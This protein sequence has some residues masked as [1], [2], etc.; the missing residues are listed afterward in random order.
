MVQRPEGLRVYP[1]DQWRPRRFRSHL[2]GR[3]GRHGWPRR[4]AEAELRAGAGT[5]RPG[6][7]RQSAPGLT[8]GRAEAPANVGAIPPV[9]LARLL[10]LMENA[11]W[12]KKT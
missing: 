11:H 1:A 9:N 7:G 2:G 4:G 5:A 8:V 6:F 12:R 3:A 10:I